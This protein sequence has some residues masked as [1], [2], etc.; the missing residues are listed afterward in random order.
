MPWEFLYI[1]RHYSVHCYLK[2]LQNKGCYDC[3]FLTCFSF[4]LAGNVLTCEDVLSR[5][6]KITKSYCFSS[7]SRRIMCVHKD[8]KVLRLTRSSSLH[9]QLQ[10]VNVS[11]CRK[12]KKNQTKAAWPSA[13]IPITD[14][15]CLVWSYLSHGLSVQVSYSI[16]QLVH[17][18]WILEIICAVCDP[19]L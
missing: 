10:P 6:R 1:R 4:S 13:H 19:F 15:T 12:P 7:S 8:K 3:G 18:I 11:M 2:S 5:T 14:T 9:K 16:L 17:F